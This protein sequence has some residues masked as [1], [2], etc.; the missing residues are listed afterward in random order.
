MKWNKN[1]VSAKKKCLDLNTIC[2]WLILIQLHNL[3]DIQSHF[4]IFSCFCERKKILRFSSL[5]T[6]VFSF[7]RTSL[8]WVI[9]DRRQFWSKMSI[10]QISGPL[11][12]PSE[13]GPFQRESPYT[14]FLPYEKTKLETVSTVGSR[15]KEFQY[16]K[17]VR[18][19]EFFAANQIFTA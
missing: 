8:G 18:N 5:W 4:V 11:T 1:W 17:N 3:H 6:K 15:Y 2:Y 16:K 14:R 9:F 7:S 13:N 12:S 10:P 19:K